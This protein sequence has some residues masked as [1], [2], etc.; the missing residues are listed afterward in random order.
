MK[1]IMN[2][3]EGWT[4]QWAPLIMNIY[5]LS[6]HFYDELIVT[7]PLSVR[8]CLVWWLLSSISLP[9]KQS[10][11]RNQD[12]HSIPLLVLAWWQHSILYKSHLGIQK[13]CFKFLP[14]YVV[15]VHNIIYWVRTRWNRC[16]CWCC[17]LCFSKNYCCIE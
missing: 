7:G 17:N 14:I 13:V 5:V 2:R 9:E 10:D 16:C 1:V 15:H 3:I 8:T 12:R 11:R 4:E 6:I